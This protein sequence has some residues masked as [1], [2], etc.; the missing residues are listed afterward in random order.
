MSA[1][2]DSMMRELYNRDGVFSV[3]VD[4]SGYK[5]SLRVAGVASGGITRMQLLC[6]DLAL[7]AEN[8]DWVRRPDFLI[9]D[10]VV[11]DGVDPRQVATGLALASRT[12]EE[13]GAQYICT[14]NSSD[15]PDDIEKQDWFHDG[16]RRSV[17]DTDE[18][19]ILGVAF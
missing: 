7:M 13:L 17:L 12:A 4:D 15:V 19:G 14:M 18:G 11:F 1:R 8:S 10:S 2:F 6:F 16:V 3:S 9:H 5:F